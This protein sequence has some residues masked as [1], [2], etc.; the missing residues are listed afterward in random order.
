MKNN[1]PESPSEEYL[2]QHTVGELKALSGPIY[3]V[4][5]DPEWPCHF[6]KEAHRIQAA[7]GDRALRIEHTGS[8]SVPDL[9]A[10]PVIDIVL[11]VADSAQ[12]AEYVPA[13][14]RAGYQLQIREPAWYEHRLFQ[15]PDPEV[16][17][18]VFS[19][20]CPEIERML[21]FRDWL[22]IT[23]GDRD[24]YARCKRGVAQQDWK[25]IQDYA[26]AKTA[27]IE[28]ILARARNSAKA[29]G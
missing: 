22:R 28:E 19:A 5:Y 18:H 26:D 2:R 8:T 15:R 12:E 21:A 25:Y 4:E 29:N 6:Q 17:L 24:L 9:P 20:D 1:A 14:E 10:K 23:P 11:A 7:L 13:L 27:V 3:L 16:D